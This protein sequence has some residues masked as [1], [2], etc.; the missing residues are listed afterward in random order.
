[1]LQ[2]YFFLLLLLIV[3]SLRRDKGDHI[4]RQHTNDGR[5]GKFEYSSCI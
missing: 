2:L 4:A 1:M 5:E 3:P